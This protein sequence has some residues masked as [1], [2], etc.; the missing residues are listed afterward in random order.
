MPHSESG[1]PGS[2]ENIGQ[3]ISWVPLILGV[4]WG[5]PSDRKSM[6]L[7]TSLV[8]QWLGLCASTPGDMGSIPGQRT[9]I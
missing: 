1:L 8:V 9:K 5:H 6:V 3:M 4:L 2:D 7:G